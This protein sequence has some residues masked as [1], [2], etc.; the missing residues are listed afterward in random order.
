[1]PT[2]SDDSGYASAPPALPAGLDVAVVAVADSRHSRS[3]GRN[4]WRAMDDYAALLTERTPMRGLAIPLTTTDPHTVA[5]RIV[6]LPSRVAAVL[7]IGLG[8]TEVARTHALVAMQRASLLITSEDE[9]LAAAI[10]AATTMTLHNLGITPEHSAVGIIGAHRAPLLATVLR[11]LDVATVRT[12]QDYELPGHDPR[13]VSADHDVM[14]D[15][16]GTG[17]AWTAPPRTILVPKDP[18]RIVALALP[19]LLCALC[20]HRAVVLTPPVLA[21]AAWAIPLLTP[22]GRALPELHDPH[23][24]QVVARNVSRVLFPD[25]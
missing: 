22:P 19:G 1:M 14:V 4:A 25:Q 13:P 15:L 23:L 12:Y 10:A 11:E 17:S 2:P 7:L 21:A 24:V 8:S 20:G 6:E 3:A 9:V 16:T 18:F 5:E